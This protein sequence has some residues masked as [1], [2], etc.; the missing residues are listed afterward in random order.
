MKRNKIHSL[1][2]SIAVLAV[3]LSCL[4]SGAVLPATAAENEP[5]T[6]GDEVLVNGDFS[7]FDQDQ[8][9]LPNWS[10][11]EYYNATAGQNGGAG[12]RLNNNGAMV[13]YL[14]DV[15]L[16][17]VTTYVLSFA[18]LDVAD[19]TFYVESGIECIGRV[20]VKTTGTGE[21]KTV[22]K[23]FTTPVEIVRD[24]GV[25]EG[26]PGFIPGFDITQG[27]NEVTDDGTVNTGSENEQYASTADLSVVCVNANTTPVAVDNLSLR[28]YI[29]TTKA[30]TLQ[31]TDIALDVEDRLWFLIGTQRTVNVK[32]TN[33]ADTT[34]ACDAR[35]LTWES[36]DETIAT[37]EHGRITAKAAGE[38][39]ITATLNDAE[40]AEGNPTTLTA[41]VKVKVVDY[42][43]TEDA[44]FSLGV[45]LLQDGKF[46]K[47]VHTN[48][49][50]SPI[51]TFV[52]E[53]QGR[54]G[55]TGLVLDKLNQ[56][57]YYKKIT[58]LKKATKYAFSFDYLATPNNT[59]FVNSE[60][61]GIDRY[62]IST[63]STA[64]GTWKTVTGVGTTP[65]NL[66]VNGSTLIAVRCTTLNA[67]APVV[68]DN[69]VLCEYI[70]ETKAES[71]ELP[72]DVILYKGQSTTLTPIA[73][74][75]GGNVN[76]TTWTTNKATV[77]TVNSGV[78]TAVGEGEAT[79]TA[80]AP[81]GLTASCVVTVTNP[82]KT[83]PVDLV[84]DNLT[85]TGDNGTGQVKPGTPLTFSV[86][87]S[88]KGANAVPAG[89]AIKLDI[90]MDG[91]WKRTLTYTDGLAAGESV[92]VTDNETWLAEEGDHMMSVRVNADWS[93]YEADANNT[94]LKNNTY[95]VGLRVASDQISPSDWAAKAVAEAG[96][97]RLTF[98]DEFTTGSVVDITG[99]GR[100]GYKWYTNRPYG[101]RQ[102]TTSDYDI[103]D[104]VLTIKD[105]DKAGANL[106]LSS[107]DHVSRTG[108]AFNEGYFEVRFKIMN[109]TGN[110]PGHMPGIWSFPERKFFEISGENSRWVEVDWME[111]WG[112]SGSA[113]EGYY[114][115]TMHD[116]SS[117]SYPGGEARYQNSNAA[118]YGLGD[119][120]WHTMGF[121]WERNRLVSYLDGVEVMH[122]LWD[123]DSY[124][125]RGDG[126]IGQYALMDEDEQVLILGAD[127]NHPM[128]VDYVRV[129]QASEPET[130]SNA[131]TLSQ[132]DVTMYQNDQE[133][134]VV[135][136]PADEDAGTLTW[137][138]SDPFVVTVHGDGRLYARKAG[139][140]TV[141]ATNANGVT[142]LCNVTVKH[143]V[144]T[145]GDFE[146]ELWEDVILPHWSRAR[147]PYSE[148]ILNKMSIVEDPTDTDRSDGINHV[149]KIPKGVTYA[150]YWNHPLK[151]S[152][153]YVIT[154]KIR[155]ENYSLFSNISNPVVILSCGQHLK[156]NVGTVTQVW[157]DFTIKY[158]TSSEPGP[159]GLAIG[160][161][162]AL[163]DTIYLDDLVFTV[164]GDEA[165]SSYALTL[166][167]MEN[168]KVT[169]SVDGE[170][171]TV[172]S[173]TE[174]KPGTRVDVT[175]NPNSD[176]RLRLGS[177]ETVYTLAG[178]DEPVTREV[179][180]TTE[181]WDGTSEPIDG[182]TFSFTMP[183]ADTTLNAVFEQTAS[184]DKTQ[185]PAATLG[186]SVYKNGDTV[187]QGVRFL[188]RLYATIKEDAVYVTYEG[189]TYK[190]TEF[191]SLLKRADNVAGELTLEGHADHGTDS[192]ATRI[193]KTT[194][195]SA[196]TN[197]MKLVNYT[198]KYLDFTIVMTSNT[199][200]Y[201][202]FV[203][204]EYTT[205]AYVTLENGT[206]LYTD[207]F[208]DNVVDALARIR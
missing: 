101:D 25:N 125:V 23:K 50:S 159:F 94:A 113:P 199:A 200:Q 70:D 111:Y 49:W 182:N 152:T 123:K 91:T 124:A 54:G 181:T 45:N 1:L 128:K 17:P 74:P 195:Y 112:I 207:T 87:M 185:L 178:T 63:G 206:T 21:W 78:V 10:G 173:G 114:T 76:G 5:Y 142:V 118:Q 39:T 18:Y 67:D 126:V 3:L 107:A 86:T 96:M 176:Y 52:K 163:S 137:A 58:G 143:N 197:S 170:T 44:P 48:Y 110:A 11:T 57:I 79:I 193:W 121:L 132:T 2:A 127:E 4:L 103:T 26:A 120:E 140:A 53:G 89:Q 56:T 73:T 97:D 38:T 37:V 68:M 190:V 47:E 116:E 198:D 134:L 156:A 88:N 201:Y 81:S 117:A 183:E 20:T 162:T 148:T 51:D 90:A 105:K 40:D 115:I 150:N 77:A 60:Q 203:S 204:Q 171:M 191:G 184:D 119:G 32:L 136:V 61:L 174:I 172:T 146:F 30:T 154:G 129:W 151:P 130:V 82:D 145:G 205:C 175:V 27:D 196:S 31:F 43:L 59:I 22:S 109:P 93:I 133:K 168:G 166:G 179:L 186:T 14:G 147:R 208:T 160:T 153:T 72:G 138:S 95:Q 139:T 19:A 99:S 24:E 169:L 189:D 55:S 108:Y 64:D 135:T 122:L 29:P 15:T 84:A 104:G 66:N 83:A 7:Q 92:T 131:M 194:A 46:E 102:L 98:N 155:R 161:S 202:S 177:L 144:L 36:E 69:F 80:R 8:G 35:K 149:L 9:V 167:N 16:E 85:W 34:L 187:A 165:K 192:P 28:E 71:I 6:L 13:E 12:L 141:S 41:S 157:Q 158:T 62:T 180:N 100:E 65:A 188:N 42:T 33:S 75:A 164:E 106:C